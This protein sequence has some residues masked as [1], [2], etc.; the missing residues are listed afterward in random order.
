MVEF[1]I[2]TRYSTGSPDEEALVKCAA[3]SGVVLVGR[4]NTRL[5]VMWRGELKVFNILQ[6]LEFNSYRKR[7]SVIAQREDDGAI[8][9]SLLLPELTTYL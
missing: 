9:V 3:R 2:F 5:S 7:M 1:F 6:T 8:L 4:E